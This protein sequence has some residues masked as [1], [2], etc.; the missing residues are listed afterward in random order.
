MRPAGLP[1]LPLLRGAGGEV[2]LDE[3]RDAILRAGD[4]LRF[5]GHALG[6][7]A[8]ARGCA[9]RAPA[10]VRA[11]LT[12][13]SSWLRAVVPRRSKRR[14]SLPTSRSA[15][16]R[17]EAVDE[18]AGEVDHAVTRLERGAD[19]HERGALG[20]VAALGGGRLRGLGLRLRG[21]ARL[22]A[23][24]RALATSGRR[25]RRLGGGARRVVVRARL[26]RFAAGLRAALRCCG[27]GGGGVSA[28]CWVSAP[29]VGPDKEITLSLSDRCYPSNTCL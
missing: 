17:A 10:R 18:L 8:H 21:L 16:A 24:D 6:L 11:F 13:R 1:G 23:R 4:A 2:E 12:S 15:A 14:M 29:L 3:R 28:I 5:D 26:R 25:A 22:V 20:D 19:V 9:A 7:A 27:G